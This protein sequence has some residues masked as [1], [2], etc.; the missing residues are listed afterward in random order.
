M[1]TEVPQVA[2]MWWVFAVL[3]LICI[4]TGIIAIVWPGITLLALGLIF[5]IY[6]MVAA[7]IEIV[8]AITGPPGGRAIS[9]ILGVIALIAGLICIRRP[10]ASLL[11]I[12][13]A[14][15]IYLI[16]SGVI[17]IVLAFDE[18]ERRGWA[19]ALGGLD[20]LAG[21]VI[22]SWPG[23]GLATLAVFFAITMFVRGVFAMLIGFRLR[24]M[25]HKEPPPAHTAHLAT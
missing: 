25:R 22:L 16:A 24:G 14:I 20:T 21:I 11:A 4:V 2:R 8:E 5:G 6:L 13:I 10:G 3:G 12:V 15:G 23:I 7:V 1:F 19:I 17:R 9:A 18:R